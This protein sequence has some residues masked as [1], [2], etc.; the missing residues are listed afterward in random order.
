MDY[1]YMAESLARLM[2]IPV[3]L[4]KDDS[5][6]GLYH[7]TKFKPD[8]A[9]LEEPNIFRSTAAVS[10]YMT[11]NLLFYGLLRVRQAPYCFVIGPAA[12]VMPDKKMANALLHSIG[13]P[14][15]RC[16]ELLNYLS[17]LPTY[18]LRIFLQIL[19]TMNYAMNGEKL[20]V[21]E[22]LLEDSPEEKAPPRKLSKNK[23]G[24]DN[25]VHNTYEL[26]TLL[27]SYVEHG[28]TEE[29]RQLYRQ[30]PGGRAGTMAD[31]AL[32]Q[33]KNTLICTATLAARAAIRGGLDNETALTLS[34]IYIQ[35]AEM[36]DS[37]TGLARLNARMVM[38]FTRRVADLQCGTCRSQLMSRARTYILAH[39]GE[40]IT[41]ADLS[42]A[43]GL[44]RTY[45]SRRFSAETGMTP[46]RY[47]TALRIDEAKRLLSVTRKPLCDIAGF[48]GFS[49]QNHFQKVFKRLTGLTPGEYRKQTAHDV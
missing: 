34:D 41:T 26:E 43:L 4:Y 49:S 37:Y 16:T 11:E 48:L 14:I 13:E 6:A 3:R 8:L 25:T 47:V 22:L 10:Y 5:F 1:E 29:L 30:S 36:L 21:S 2:G 32:R 33:E 44:N 31:N 24:H 9:I 27:L 20:D 17:A 28:R 15:S 23:S 19:I 12:H 40:N 46:G 7:H 39:M 18:P 38:D 42:Q 45:L 35:E